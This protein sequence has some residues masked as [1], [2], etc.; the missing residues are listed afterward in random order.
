MACIADIAVTSPRDFLLFDRLINIFLFAYIFAT[1]TGR[2]VGET[3][4]SVRVRRF[5]AG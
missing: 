2:R 1:N 5:V 4:G 3:S